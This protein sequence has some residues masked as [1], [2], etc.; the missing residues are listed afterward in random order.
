MTKVRG[1]RHVHRS[2]VWENLTSSQT[3]YQEIRRIL[4]IALPFI[5]LPDKGAIFSTMTYTGI[6]LLEH[7]KNAYTSSTYL[8]MGQ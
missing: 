4:D 5:S 6:K 7:A 8:I 3:A 2:R 1:L